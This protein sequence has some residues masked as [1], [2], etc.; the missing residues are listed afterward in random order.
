MAN[1]AFL[2]KL[3]HNQAMPFTLAHAAAVLPLRKLKL[4]WSAVVIGT[5]AP[6]FTLFLA[7]PDPQRESHELPQ[8]LTFALPMALLTLWLFHRLV[9][10]PLV[11]LAPEGLRLRLT[12]CVRPF[13]FAGL[14]RFATIVGSICIG[15]ATH[16][17]WDSFTHQRT[18]AYYRWAWLRAPGSCLLFGHWLVLP[19]FKLLQFASSVVGCLALALWFVLWY[20]DTAPATAATQAAFAPSRRF[21]IVSALLVLPWI[22]AAA[23]ALRGGYQA[24]D[25]HR[26]AVVVNYLVILPAAILAIELLLYGLLTTR[27]LSSARAGGSRNSG[28]ALR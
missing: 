1:S 14:R 20:R 13:P 10:R 26:P 6:D 2:P 7:L 3:R 15:M 16:V 17:L 24:D 27:I 5:F 22:V 9:K 4:V 11:E 8:L 23:F 21:G 28:L 18:W 25:F 12:P 19:H